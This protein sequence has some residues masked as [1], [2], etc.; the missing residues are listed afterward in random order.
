VNELL[1]SDA[2]DPDRVRLDAHLA[3]LHRHTTGLEASMILGGDG[4]LRLL[5]YLT[6]ANLDRMHV[7]TP[8]RAGNMLGKA[9]RP[10]S[11]ESL[12]QRD[13]SL[14]HGANHGPQLN[15]SASRASNGHGT[16]REERLLRLVDILRTEQ[17][18]ASIVT[19]DEVGRTG[20]R[21]WRGLWLPA[22]VV[23]LMGAAAI[24]YASRPTH[25]FSDARPHLSPEPAHPIQSNPTAKIGLQPQPRDGTG[26]TSVATDKP[27]DPALIAPFHGGFTQGNPLQPLPTIERQVTN[28]S[29]VAEAAPSLDGNI[30]ETKPVDL[31]A[32]KHESDSLANPNPAAVI[33]DVSGSKPNKPTLMV[34][35]PRGSLRSETNAR[36]LATRI[37]ANFA[38]SDFEAQS[39]LPDDAVIYFLEESS[40]N[41]ARVV[42]KSLGDLGYRW[43][44]VNG[45]SP[46][47]VHRNMIEAWL[48]R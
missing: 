38:K 17:V 41:L 26:D 24:L 2:E 46:A 32:P 42:G 28:P 10:L 30:G 14:A 16:D 23:V 7:E 25:V 39:A 9:R 44:I 6:A 37:E 33:G 34:Y 45:S 19:K 13:E 48:P 18:S 8:I 11:Q 22:V 1:R 47:G 12:G 29:S 3:R 21:R 40:H 43:R 27:S 4:I 5:T 35:F 36:S 20:L 31:L 15:E